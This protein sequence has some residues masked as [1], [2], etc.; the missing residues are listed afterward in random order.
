MQ[1]QQPHVNPPCTSLNILWSKLRDGFFF[2]LN[3]NVNV[4]FTRNDKFL[5]F[6]VEKRNT[7]KADDHRYFKY[8]PHLSPVKSH[9][10]TVRVGVHMQWLESDTLVVG[11]G[12]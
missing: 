3:R 7:R 5:F 10:I 9:H 1:I 6:F 4:C 11:R 8:N 12:F 2:P